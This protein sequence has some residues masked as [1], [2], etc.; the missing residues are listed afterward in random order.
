[1]IEKDW[2]RKLVNQRVGRIRRAFSWGVENE[3]GSPVVLQAFA[4]V[5]GLQEG[6]TTAHKTD[7]AELVAD[8]V[9]DATLPQLRPAVR[10]MGG[11]CQPVVPVA[12]FVG[13]NGPMWGAG[14]TFPPSPS[15]GDPRSAPPV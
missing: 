2:N 5:K 12:R 11:G 13:R 4:A 8:E 6:C 14:G 10:A 7:P 1:M 9:V 3:L 15:P